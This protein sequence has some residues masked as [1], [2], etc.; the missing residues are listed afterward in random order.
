VTG[1]NPFSRTPLDAIR[2]AGGRSVY[3][4]HLKGDTRIGLNQ[5]EQ[6]A[7]AAQAAGASL[8]TWFPEESEHV[9]TPAVYPQEFE[10]RMVAFFSEALGK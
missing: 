8:T 7:E 1:A 5:S 6:L 10:Q 9:Q 3:I 2:K 4:T